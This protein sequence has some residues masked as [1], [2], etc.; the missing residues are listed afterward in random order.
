MVEA[1]IKAFA[2]KTPHGVDVR[3]IGDT[4]RYAIVNWLVAGARN[5]RTCMVTSVMSNHV[6][7]RLWDERAHEAGAEVIEV[8]ISEIVHR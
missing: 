2:V 7:E 1:P 4:R 3:T 8:A 5:P 6:I